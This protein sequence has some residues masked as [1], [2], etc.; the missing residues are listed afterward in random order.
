MSTAYS[1]VSCPPDVSTP[2]APAPLW[3]FEGRDRAITSFILQGSAP[4][5]V[6]AAYALSVLRVELIVRTVCVRE[7]PAWI[8]EAGRPQAWVGLRSCGPG[9]GG[10]GCK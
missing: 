10:W 5:Q 7:W 6:S 2:P 9:G 1:T 8:D 4:A 3:Y